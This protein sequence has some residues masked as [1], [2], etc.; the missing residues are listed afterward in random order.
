MDAGRADG[1]AG[2]DSLDRFKEV[3]LHRVG[4]VDDDY[5]VFEILDELTDAIFLFGG[6]LE[7]CPALVFWL[8]FDF[9]LVMWAVGVFT[10]VTGDDEESRIRILFG[11]VVDGF[12]GIEIL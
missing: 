6:D 9:V 1:D 7:I 5:D 2:V 8:P 3:E 11:V 4:G 12:I 10:R